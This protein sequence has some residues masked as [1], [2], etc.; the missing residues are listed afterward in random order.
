MS[1][2]TFWE[3]A[4]KLPP[5]LVRLLA[6]QGGRPMS[7]SGIAQASGL[8][9]H[10]VDALSWSL[11][12]NTVPLGTMRRFLTGCGVD[13]AKFSEWK[14]AVNYLESPGCNFRYLRRHKDWKSTYEPML[15]KWL[16]SVSPTT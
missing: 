13:F 10:T 14:R 16:K 2:M 7:M 3:R 8:E 6:R 15:A 9:M 5:I 4:D 12:W 1:K 11:D